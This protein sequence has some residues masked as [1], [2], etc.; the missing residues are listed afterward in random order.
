RRKASFVTLVVAVVVALTASAALADGIR[1]DADDDALSPPFSTTVVAN[2]GVG[3][4]IEYPFS[5]MVVRAGLTS[6]KVFV[7]PTDTV[8][9]GI[10]RTGQWLGSPAG[11]PDSL[12]LS[13]YLE[14]GT[15]TIAITVPPDAC[16]LTQTMHVSLVATASNGRTLSPNTVS[17][18][19]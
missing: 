5:V 19:F 6:T 13:N 15:G 9:V 1:G 2:Q 17:M 11:S 3:T 14:M 10:T 7:N 16:G 8:Q 18:D 12:T 4:T